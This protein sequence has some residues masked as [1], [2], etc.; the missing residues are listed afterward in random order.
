M[1][2]NSGQLKFILCIKLHEMQYE[3]FLRLYSRRMFY[4]TLFLL[5]QFRKIYHAWSKKL[6]RI[7]LML[8]TYMKDSDTI[9]QDQYL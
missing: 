8:Q 9:L 7:R 2:S 4:E 5:T 3:G 6:R 1:F